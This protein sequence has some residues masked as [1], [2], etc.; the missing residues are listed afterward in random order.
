MIDFRYFLVSM[1]GVFLALAVGIALGAGP[2][3]GDLDQELRSD[4]RQVGREKDDLRGRISQLQ[5]VDRYRDTFAKDLAPNLVRGQLTGQDVV[6][7]ALPG[8]DTAVVKDVEGIVAAA[9]GGVTGTVQVRPKWADPSEQQFLEDLAGRLAT[10][11]VAPATAAGSA[12][13]QAG[14]VLAR[15]LVTDDDGAPGRGD[16]ATA[17]VVGAFGEGGLVDAPASLARASFAVV[18]APPATAGAGPRVRDAAV[19][20]AASADTPAN[21][22]WVALARSLDDAGQGVVMAGE[23]SAA[24]GEQGVLASLRE[25][26]RASA[27]VSS[28]D[29]ADLPSGQVAIVWALVEQRRGGAGH[30]GAVGTTDG[31]LPKA[32]EGPGA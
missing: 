20:E 18:V 17:T 28:V 8:A 10:G 9:G 3:R 15:A 11:R 2:F 7:V 6:L 4:L 29:V 30:Y 22:A 27:D 1:T 32:P 25:D 13:E 21:A 31:A 23:T 5:H 24:E 19:N 16:A 14:S 26:S 12:Y